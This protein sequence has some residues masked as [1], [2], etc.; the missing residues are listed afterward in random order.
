M[1]L[2]N[3]YDD[4]S[5][6]SDGNFNFQGGQAFH[7]QGLVKGFETGM[8]ERDLQTDAWYKSVDYFDYQGRNIQSFSQ[9]HAGI[10]RSEQQY[11]FN[12]ALKKC[13]FTHG[14][15]SNLTTIDYDHQDRPTALWHSIN[16]GTAKQ[17]ATYTYDDIGRMTTKTVS[18][19]TSLTYSCGNNAESVMNGAFE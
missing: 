4:Y 15:Y 12:G 17:L 6:N 7:S 18:P 11:R 10:D 2:I 19:N 3:F 5:W 1:R 13:R 8:L 9:N 14:V 16:G